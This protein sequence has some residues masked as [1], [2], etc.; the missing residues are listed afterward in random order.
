GM[1]TEGGAMGEEGIQMAE[2]LNHPISLVRAWYG[3]GFVSLRKGDLHQAIA[4]LERG[5]AL[6]HTWHIRDWCCVLAAALGY[7][8]TLA[9]HH[10]E[11]LLLLKQAVE[12]F[13]SLRGGRPSSLWLT[14]WSEASRRASRLEDALA[15]ARRALDLARHNRERGNEAYA[16]HQLGT[17]H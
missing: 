4:R 6:C 8:Y 2:A 3:S 17:V 14:W 11:P 5:L 13:T 16:L 10:P 7:A 15:C 12:G 9:G 1:F